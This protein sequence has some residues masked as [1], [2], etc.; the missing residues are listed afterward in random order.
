[1]SSRASSRGAIAPPL[2][3]VLVLSAN[4]WLLWRYAV[5]PGE[6]ALYAVLRI[7]GAKVH[8]SDPD[9]GFVRTAF[10]PAPRKTTVFLPGEAKAWLWLAAR[11]GRLED[12][13]LLD[14]TLSEDD[15]KNVCRMSELGSLVIGL[16]RAPPSMWLRLSSL[17]KFHF[18]SLDSVNIGDAGIAQISRIRSLT[19]LSV[20]KCGV[21]DEG[22]RQLRGLKGLESLSIGGFGVTR[23]TLREWRTLSKLLSL[24]LDSCKVSD[25]MLPT[26]AEFP[27]LRH[28]F[29][30]NNPITDKGLES[31]SRMGTLKSLDLSGTLI[32]DAGLDRLSGM[33]L[34]RLILGKTK[35]T[36]GA[37]RR[38]EA[39]V[40]GLK[41]ERRVPTPDFEELLDGN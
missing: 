25:D 20:C 16:S 26:L 6:E 23:A 13:G 12:L 34:S 28:L 37:V 17:S 19:Y 36:D 29:L 18:L 39:R 35:V 30:R 8:V 40:P 31:V 22:I 5:Y 38:L 15:V 2:L 32:T 4:S 33:R 14:V 9:L 41:V 24:S 11:L 3:V 10:L 1:M 27:S 7:G 21:T